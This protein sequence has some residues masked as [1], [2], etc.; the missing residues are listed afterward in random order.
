MKTKVTIL[1]DKEI[2]K[3]AHELG[4]NVSKACENWLKRYVQAFPYVIFLD[5]CLASVGEIAE[6]AIDHD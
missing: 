4:I 6:F 5:K 2:L 1:I 3:K